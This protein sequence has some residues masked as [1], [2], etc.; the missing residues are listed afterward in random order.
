MF[1]KII[2]DQGEPG[3]EKFVRWLRREFPGE[4]DILEVLWKL[5]SNGWAGSVHATS[6]CHRYEFLGNQRDFYLHPFE[7]FDLEE[8]L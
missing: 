7:S 8:H 2:Q 5:E 3:W 1:Y 4:T 6:S